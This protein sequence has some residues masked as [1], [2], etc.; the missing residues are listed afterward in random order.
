M[1]R[2]WLPRPYR[3]G[4]EAQILELTQAVLGKTGSLEYWNW[5]FKN[6]PDGAPILWVAECK[7]RIVGQYVIIP[8]RLKVG[9]E[10]IM[11]SLSLDTMTHPDFRHRG[12]FEVL[13]RKTYEEARSRGVHITYGMPNQYSYPGFI[14]KLEWFNI[15]QIPQ[16]NKIL[17]LW[18]VVG[19]LRQIPSVVSR[20]VSTLED[21]IS[22]KKRDI[23]P[24]LHLPGVEIRSITS[25]DDRVDE[26]WRQASTTREVMVV[27]DRRHLNWRYSQKPGY[28]YAIY[29]AERAGT[30]LGYIITIVRSVK[31]G[32]GN[33]RVGFI[34][35]LLT[36]PRDEGKAISRVLITAA[37]DELRRQ[38]AAVVSCWMLKETPYY[39][40]LRRMGF[41]PR[42]AFLPLGARL[43]SPETSKELLREHR[44]WFF[45]MGDNDSV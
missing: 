38:Q 13:G 29:Q 28:D 43:N 12:I 19:N 18:R 32:R 34:A 15:C 8:Q 35:D 44:N 20:L 2:E 36:L 23:M 7:G 16:M 31:F 1:R 4:D 27:R 14:N 11:G 6:N 39:R 30:I 5:Q 33:L 41:W 45:T 3:E 10:I 42:R 40:V 21:K 22:P 17:N 26:L 25:F 24:Y 9:D 37:I